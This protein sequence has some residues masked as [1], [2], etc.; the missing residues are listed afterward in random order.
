MNPDLAFVLG[1]LACLAAFPALLNS[2]STSGRT[3]R[4][5]AVLVVFGLSM[6]VYAANNRQG[7][8]SA[9]DIPRAFGSVLSSV[10]GT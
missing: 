4:A 8:Y 6:I 7:G 2:F 5:P 3:F 1:I 9:E 10:I